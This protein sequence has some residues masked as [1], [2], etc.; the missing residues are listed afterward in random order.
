MCVKRLLLGRR[1]RD[2]YQ[3]ELSSILFLAAEAGGL[4][5]TSGDR[6]PRGWEETLSLNDPA[7]VENPAVC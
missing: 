1:G 3:W 7:A 4:L 6:H 5:S 2:H